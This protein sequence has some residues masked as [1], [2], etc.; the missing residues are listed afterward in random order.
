MAPGVIVDDY[1]H[2]GYLETSHKQVHDYESTKLGG[3]SEILASRVNQKFGDWRDEFFSKGYVVLKGVVPRERA[4]DYQRR[5][6]EWLPKFNLGLDLNDKSTWTQEHLPV[7]MN[8]G[9]V[10]NYCAAHEAWMWE[11]RR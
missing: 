7:M 3:N 1:D 8:A 6:L 9:M 4:L 11:A 10:L 5:A 2:S